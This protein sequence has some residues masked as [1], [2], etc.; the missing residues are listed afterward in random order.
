[1][2]EDRPLNMINRLYQNDL[3][4]AKLMP[5]STKEKLIITKLSKNEKELEERISSIVSKPSQYDTI[6]KMLLNIHDVPENKPIDVLQ[7][8]QTL[9]K[10]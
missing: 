2:Q 10:N 1:M 4:L 9:S 5:L 7:V 8:K 3:L 6:R